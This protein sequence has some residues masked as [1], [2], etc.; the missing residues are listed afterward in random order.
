MRGENLYKFIRKMFSP[1]VPVLYVLVPVSAFA[2]I[3]SLGDFGAPAAVCYVSYLLS[4]YTFGAVCCLVLPVLGK[5][6]WRILSKNRFIMSYMNDIRVHVSV[7]LYVSQAINLA[8]AV[9]QFT[10]AAQHNSVWYGTMGTY[11]SL[12]FLMRCYLLVYIGRHDP[13]ADRRAERKK[14]RFCGRVL[15][16]LNIVLTLVVMN[17]IQEYHYT[18]QNMIVAIAMAAYTFAAMALTLVH[19]VQY[20]KYHSPVFTASVNISLVSCLVS[21][22]NLETSM[23]ATFGTEQH[24]IYNLR[25]TGITGAV[26]F[27]IILAVAYSMIHT[28]R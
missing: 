23:L 11:Y 26:I 12:L 9:F 16:I 10:M 6:I 21:L 13:G 7:G 15:L 17:I 1:P 28:S 8:Y 4:A 18:A 24:A 27:V 14:C 22:L 2:L 5:R 19:I 3:W 20:R 25:L